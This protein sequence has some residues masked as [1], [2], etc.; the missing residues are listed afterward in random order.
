ME[1]KHQKSLMIAVSGG[2]GAVLILTFIVS[3]AFSLP[4]NSGG[5][6]YEYQTLI[7]AVIAATSIYVT[8][9]Q[10]AQSMRRKSLSARA[11]LNDSLSELCTFSRNCFSA[12]LNDDES[13]M[14]NRQNDSIDVL[15][16]AIE[17]LDVNTSETVY[18]LVIQ[19]QVNTARLERYFDLSEQRSIN[20]QAEYLYDAVKLR[21]MAINLFPYARKEVNAVSCRELS[22]DKMHSSLN[23]VY[24]FTGRIL[25]HQD[26]RLGD[27]IRNI[28][29][30]HL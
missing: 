8:W 25:A 19:Y 16:H 26:D 22:N 1:D 9:F 13:M 2:L 6:A 5:W 28:D 7:G 11:K 30:R 4:E 15:K 3:G 12:I 21:A 18:E 10:Y 29:M 24:G 14:L 20:D 17:Y 27:L 23:G